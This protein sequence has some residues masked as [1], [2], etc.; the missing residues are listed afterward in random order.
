ML[1]AE[2]T[3]L[4]KLED[5][6]HKRVI[7]QDEAVHAVAD[8]VRR[9]RAGMGDESDRSVRSSSSAPPVLVKPNWQKR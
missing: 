9:S 6:L 3:K 5:E 8:A 4:L 1:E 2:R 7:G